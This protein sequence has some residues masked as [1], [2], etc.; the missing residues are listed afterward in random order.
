MGRKIEPVDKRVRKSKGKITGRK[1]MTLLLGSL[2]LYLAFNFGQGFY[3]IHQ[4][5]N[6]ISSLEQEVT[7]LQEIN[8]KLSDEVDHLHSP[9]AIEKIAREKLGLIRD[10]EIV[11]MRAREAN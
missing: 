9:E 4:L 3:Q 5:K 7:E 8:T 10:G 1:F 2:V 11:I 6:E